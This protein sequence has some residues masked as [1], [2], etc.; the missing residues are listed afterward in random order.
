MH[1]AFCLPCCLHKLLLNRIFSIFFS[2]S[3][4]YSMNVESMKREYR[5][6]AKEAQKAKL[7]AYA[8][9][10]KFRVGAAILT[11]DGTIYSGCNIENSS[12]GLT[13]CAE[14]V[15][16]FNAVAA[17]ASK[18]SAMAIV[19]DDNGFTSPCGACRQVLSD[20]AGDVDVVMMDSNERF[21]IMKLST[22]LPLAFT[23]KTL[24]RNLKQ[25]N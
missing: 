4:L 21:K 6:L 24:M 15:A 23:R 20:L 19:S 25:K 1:Y 8:P 11:N 5:E 9:F 2:N 17:G 22:L 7:H 12:Y 10:S 13:I 14:R 3:R 18:F 16:I